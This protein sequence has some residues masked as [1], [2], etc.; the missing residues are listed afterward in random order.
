MYKM[1][2]KLPATRNEAH[3]TDFSS[4]LSEGT[5]SADTGI[6]DQQPPELRDNTF[7]SFKPPSLWY[8]VML[9]LAN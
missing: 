8:F 1:V 5:N 3:E 6:L 2:S 7:L 9:A 4:R